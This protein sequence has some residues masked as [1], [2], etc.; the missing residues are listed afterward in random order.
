MPGLLDNGRTDGFIL[1]AARLSILRPG[2]RRHP[3]DL[4]DF[5]LRLFRGGARQQ[6]VNPPLGTHRASAGLGL[7]PE[8][9]EQ[10]AAQRPA[11]GGAGI[12]RHG[13]APGRFLAVLRCLDKDRNAE[14]DE[15]AVDRQAAAGGEI[16]ALD[17]GDYG[18]V[19]ITKAITLDG[20]NVAYIGAAGS[21]GIT[22]SA[23]PN[24]VVIIRN[25]RIDGL[26]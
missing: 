6:Q 20:G 7:G 15:F 8:A 22:I 11:Y 12:L 19:T 13:Q 25:L 26:N 21:N 10:I 14:R 5:S 23:G 9:P 24:D 18:P 2:G 3:S 1:S 17:S 4:Y 16:D